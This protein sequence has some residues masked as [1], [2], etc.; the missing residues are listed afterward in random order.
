MNSFII[1]MLEGEQCPY[2]C[3]QVLAPSSE[4][5]GSGLSQKKLTGLDVGVIQC[6]HNSIMES[7]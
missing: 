2:F 7:I 1:S 4:A 5:S 3:L 6:V